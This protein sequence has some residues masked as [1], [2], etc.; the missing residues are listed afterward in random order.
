MCQQVFSAAFTGHIEAVYDGEALKNE[1]CTPVPHPD[2]R[3]D[4]LHTV[5]GNLLNGGRWAQD[6]ELQA[7]LGQSRL[8][9][10]NAPDTGGEVDGELA[11]HLAAGAEVAIAKLQRWLAEADAEASGE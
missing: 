9:F 10:L 3:L 7:W 6:A 11:Q 8:D 4:Y 5:L 1:L 2:T